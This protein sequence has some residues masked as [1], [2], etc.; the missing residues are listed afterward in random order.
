MNK[1]LLIIMPSALALII[2][3][4]VTKNNKSV[5]KD[6]LL[7]RA[8][9]KVASGR[10]TELNG[11]EADAWRVSNKNKDQAYHYLAKKKLKEKLAN[12]SQEDQLTH[13]ELIQE[14][15]KEI[16]A[17]VDFDPAIHNI[18]VYEKIAKKH[19]LEAKQLEDKFLEMQS[20]QLLSND[21]VAELMKKVDF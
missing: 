8:E 17:R 13:A 9:E 10:A 12:Y 1:N 15:D 21:E 2:T 11:A 16:A 6:S 5:P 4:L 18:L 20:T 14:F 7:Q 19:N 3:L